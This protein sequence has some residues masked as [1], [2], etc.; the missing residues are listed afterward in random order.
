MGFSF[1]CG[2]KKVVYATDNELDLLLAEP[3]QPTARPDELRRLPEALVEAAK[4]A[5]LLI[6]DGQY[7]DAEYDRKVG[8]GHARASTAVDFAVQAGVRQL[9]IF[10]H[11]PMQSDKDV[12]E[13]VSAC[14]ARAA[15]LESD[16][17][18]FGA[19]EGVELK[20]A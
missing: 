12:D 2:G 5:D 10:H 16:V 9:A 13:K 15:A 4:G 6:A 7:V 8:W 20:I 18:V 3:T 1:T 17:R 19:R 11:D 14:S